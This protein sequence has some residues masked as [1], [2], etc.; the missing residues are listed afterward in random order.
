MKLLSNY[1]RKTK[2]TFTNALI[3]G[4][5]LLLVGIVVLTKI[6]LVGLLLVLLAL[7]ALTLT[8]GLEI[9]FINRKIRIFFGVFGL[10]FG[11][12]EH[13]PIMDRITLV[14]V[15]VKNTMTGRTNLTTEV[16]ATY[17]QVRLY[18]QGARDYYIASMGKL[19]QCESDAD[20]LARQFNLTCEKYTIENT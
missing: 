9:D 2:P 5:V 19:S 18:P 6:L 8:E 7:F 10:R 15:Q 17:V 4:L 20:L 11:R 14:P 16:T 3:P 1:V 13:L 12:W